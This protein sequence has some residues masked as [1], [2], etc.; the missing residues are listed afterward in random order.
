[1][2]T[3]EYALELFLLTL[4]IHYGCTCSH[5]TTAS[6]S[7]GNTCHNTLLSCR[8]IDASTYASIIGAFDRKTF[9]KSVKSS[10]DYTAVYKETIIQ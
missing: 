7:N 1:M 5:L 3:E 2:D 10:T 8:T 4:N 9:L 6:N